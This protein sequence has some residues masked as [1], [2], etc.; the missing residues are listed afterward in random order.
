MKRYACWILIV[1]FSNLIVL[2]SCNQATESNTTKH[3]AK[4]QAPS[5]EAFINGFEKVSLPYALPEATMDN[6]HE[7]D[8][9]N[10]SYFFTGVHYIAAFGEERDVPDLQE[11]AEAAH[12][13]Y[14]GRLPINVASSFHAIIIRKEDGGSFYYLCLLDKEGKFISGMCT[15]FQEG[16]ASGSTARNASFNEDLSIELRQVN[17]INGQRDALSRFYEISN[18][19]I[20]NGISRES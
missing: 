2:T 14:V 8:K 1:L 9:I 3:K 13:Y 18:T 7:I 19:G 20:I 11:N 17:L 15:A 16:D 4:E 10:I 6:S 12:Y 5:L